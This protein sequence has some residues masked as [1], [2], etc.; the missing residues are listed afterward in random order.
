MQQP[1]EQNRDDLANLEARRRAYQRPR[2]RKLQPNDRVQRSAAT[3]LATATPTT[4]AVDHLR[5]QLDAI[6]YPS[7]ARQGPQK[8]G[9]AYD[10]A[11][12]DLDTTGDSALHA[13]ELSRLRTELA[14]AILDIEK[15]I[16][17]LARLVTR[18]T[19]DP[20]P[21]IDGVALCSDNQHGREGAAEWGDPAC[22]EIPAKSG[23]CT[24]EYQRERKWRATVNLDDRSE[25]AG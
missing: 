7:T 16:N 14:A 22:M 17:A 19:N 15:R 1:H 20:L 4:K 18:I 2:T 5:E 11:N 6:G 3:L 12:P 23:L 10:A 24:R 13:L 8:V 25:P 9:T 21:G